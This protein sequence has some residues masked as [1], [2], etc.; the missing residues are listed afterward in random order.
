MTLGLLVSWLLGIALTA[1]TIHA[2]ISGKGPLSGKDVRRRD[3][4]VRYWL[5]M[6]VAPPRRFM[7][8]STEPLNAL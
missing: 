6:I 1:I 8:D 5:E 7:K 3:R 2:L 4:P